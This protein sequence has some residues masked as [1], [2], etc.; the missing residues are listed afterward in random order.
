MEL[1]PLLLPRLRE[2]GNE[3]LTGG[4]GRKG[5]C[6]IIL[7]TPFKPFGTLFVYT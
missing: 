3:S 4:S 7:P 2:E 6:I 5:R 1:D